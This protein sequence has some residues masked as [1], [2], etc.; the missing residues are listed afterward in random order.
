MRKNLLALSIAAMVGGLSGVANAA[1]SSVS[2][3][4]VDKIDPV[5]VLNPTLP[6]NHPNGPGALFNVDV[7]TPAGA[8]AATALRDQVNAQ[9]A[10]GLNVGGLISP[11]GT[12]KVANNLAPGGIGGGHILLVPY[13]TTQGSNV[14][15]LNLVNTD[16]VNGKAVKLRYRGASNS[17]DLFD[18]TIYLSPGDVWTANV[19]NEGGFSRLTTE[20]N[21]CTIPSRQEIRDANNGRFLVNRVRGNQPA[22]TREGYI[23]ILNTADIPPF[24]TGTDTANPLFTAIKHNDQ[25]VAPCTAAV[26]AL[27]EN[28]LVPVAGNPD[29]P[30]R[31]GYF[32]PTGGLF[33]NWTIVN[34]QTT[35]SFSGEAD[36]VNLVTPAGRNGFGSLVWYP[37]TSDVVAGAVANTLTND[38]LLRADAAGVSIV[39]PQRLDFPDL[40]T[41]Y[42]P[43]INYVGGTPQTAPS[44]QVAAL[45]R[46]LAV[47]SITNEYLTERVVDFR[48][49]WVISMPTRRYA[50]AV[51]YRTATPVARFNAA[52][53]AGVPDSLYFTSANARINPTTGQLCVDTGNQRAWDREE[54]TRTQ[55]NISPTPNLQ[56]CGEVSVVTFNRPV[57]EGV[58]GAALAASSIE[59]RYEAGWFSMNTFGATGN[60][61]PVLGFA[62][63][64]ARGNG[65]FGGT[66]AH[67]YE[68]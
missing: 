66:W 18:I 68:R 50:A 28:P 64:Q 30:A 14:S 20:D 39:T 44:A 35:A 53:L 27:Q 32:L 42:I 40:S 10:T 57:A 63:A 62:A 19:A 4:V 3:G 16:L 17:D 60:G 12:T 47:R 33:A 25:G 54:R 9:L 26:M 8:G 7:N 38:P 43:G 6:I 58:L 49:D 46:A 56:F 45:A 22:E 37:Q 15:L 13:F 65:N 29:S 34:V 36:P 23:E 5:D 31:R 55:F 24:L 21:S 59:T 11:A 61:L 51:D 2:P 48:T 1:V 52:P 41:P 67:R